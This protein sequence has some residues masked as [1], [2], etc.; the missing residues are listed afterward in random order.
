MASID[1]GSTIEGIEMLFAHE[2]KPRETPYVL[3][4]RFVGSGDE[5]ILEY[6]VADG[7]PEDLKM[8]WIPVSEYKT[9]VA[10]RLSS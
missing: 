9:M 4:C 2:I 8:E 7:T 10:N 5:R 1:V 3:D 6:K